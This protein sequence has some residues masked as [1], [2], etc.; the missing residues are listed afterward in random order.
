MPAA[1][2]VGSTAVPL[3][4]YVGATNVAAPAEVGVGRLV[5]PLPEYVGLTRVAVPAAAGVGK[6]ADPD[7]V[8]IDASGTVNSA[9]DISPRLV[10]APPVLFARKVKYRLP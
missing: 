5:E 6:L 3:A 9:Q 2:G 1:V 7:P 8:N 10:R 4:E